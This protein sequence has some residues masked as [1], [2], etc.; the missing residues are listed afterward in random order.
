MAASV[1]PTAARLRMKLP[2]ALSTLNFGASC[3]CTGSTS[4]RCSVL[5]IM[6]WNEAK[7]IAPMTSA[8]KNTRVPTMFW[9]AS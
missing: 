6:N 4:T 5:R 8:M 9:F 2:I 7:P 1:A 3:L